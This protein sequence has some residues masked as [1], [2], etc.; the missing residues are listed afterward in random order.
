MC[1]HPKAVLQEAAS[2]WKITLSR[3]GSADR[4]P[5]AFVRQ[6]HPKQ[7]ASIIIIL[8]YRRKMRPER[9]RTVKLSVDDAIFSLSASFP[10]C[11]HAVS[12]ETG[13]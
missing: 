3:T 7:V 9:G 11:F 4:P 10:S 8:G 6:P 5:G 13:V 2:E 1:E 12:V